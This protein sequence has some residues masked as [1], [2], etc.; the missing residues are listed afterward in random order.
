LLNTLAN[1]GAVAIENA[2]M[3]DE[4]IEK[5]RMEEELSIARDL[6]V[7]ML[8]AECPHIE[9]FEIAAFSVSARE[10]GGDF[11]DFIEMDETKAGFVIGDV[12]GKSVSGALVMSAS[13][14]VFRM[15]SES[16]LTVAESMIRAN[17]RLKKDVKTGMFVALLYAVLNGRDKSVSMC[18]AGQTQPIY[19][20]AKSGTAALIETEGDTF[21]LGILDDADY[22]ETRIELVAG[23]RMIFYT[24]GIVEAMNDQE[25]MFGFDRLLEIVQKSRSA[26]ADDLLQR[27]IDDVKT[28]T[29]S[30]PQHDDL[31]VIV[32]SVRN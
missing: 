9:G 20:S 4:V 24:D 28:F 32:V 21:P 1:Q 7:S 14:S 15:L 26:T 5:E 11:Y 31:T 18:S 29:G 27:I 23:D 8:P 22:A 2:R 16:E 13:R 6:Q 17:R 10:V 19:L 12:T 25:E 30:A 3:V